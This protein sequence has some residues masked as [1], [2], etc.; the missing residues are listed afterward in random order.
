VRDPAR[1]VTVL[2]LGDLGRSPRI[3]NHALALAEDGAE[4]SLAGYDETPLD[5]GIAAHA[6]IRAWPIRSGA[7]A[8]EGAS[9]ARFVLTSLWRGALL[10]V[11]LLSLLL[12]RTPRP[13][14][15][16]VQNP[17]SLPTLPL[18]WLAA[19]L[20]GARII[21]DWHNFGYSMLAL[22]LGERHVGVRVAKA[23]ERFFGRRADAHF[24]VSKAMQKALEDDFGVPSAAVLYDRPRTIRPGLPLSDRNGAAAKI[25]ARYDVAVAPDAAIVVCPTSWTADEDMDLLLDGLAHWNGPRILVLITGRGPRRAAFENRLRSEIR[26][27]FLDFSDYHELLRAAHLGIS[28]HRSSSGVDLPMK[29]VDLFGARTPVCALDYGPCLREQ[30]EPGRTGVLFRTS[31]E[32][33]QQ[34]GELLRK[35]RLEPMRRAIEES[36]TVTWIEE[37]RKVAALTLLPP[38]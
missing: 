36:W 12:W 30:I 26:A 27:L 9:P 21:V 24:C 18:A 34:L 5:P 16:L 37:W 19:R 11:Q 6:R 31:E 14:A 13:D 28:M 17:P 3:L 32:L 23:I 2:V 8:P 15:V 7:R 29:V 33:A 1:K 20:R 35:D 4:V 25:L 22:R 10:I 38:A